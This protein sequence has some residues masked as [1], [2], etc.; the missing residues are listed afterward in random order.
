MTE[1]K[2]MKGGITTSRSHSP[3]MGLS[4]SRRSIKASTSHF[5][6]GLDPVLDHPVPLTREEALKRHKELSQRKRSPRHQPHS[7]GLY[8]S[9]KNHSEE[10]E[11]VIESSNE[12]HQNQHRVPS[13]KQDVNQKIEEYR[14]WVRQRVTSRQRE[15]KEQQ[16]KERADQHRR[17]ESLKRLASKA[18]FAL[19]NPK[20]ETTPKTS[21]KQSG[22]NSKQVSPQFYDIPRSDEEQEPSPVSKKRHTRVKQLP[23]RKANVEQRQ[24][25]FDHF[26]G[27]PIN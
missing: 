2:S 8:N 10:H 6:T 15:I 5:R 25:Q 27:K 18:K 17:S 16:E 9:S 7:S 4:S 23:T 26:F 13:N 20:P 1:N 21:K 3:M 12:H 22:P 19:G 14:A 24:H 11:I